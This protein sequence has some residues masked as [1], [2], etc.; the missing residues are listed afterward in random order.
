MSRVEWKGSGRE[1]A[2]VQH[3]TT[4]IIISVYVGEGKH[5]V[6][7]NC[8]GCRSLGCYGKLVNT[9]GAVADT[10]CLAPVF[11]GCQMRAIKRK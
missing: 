6:L 4:I 11:G 8:A 3:S 5:N 1:T 7:W 10:A 9:S 2:A